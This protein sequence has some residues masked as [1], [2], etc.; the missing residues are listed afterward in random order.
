M[1]S[2][3]HIYIYIASYSKYTIHR[4]HNSFLPLP[5]VCP[6]SRRQRC[7]GAAPASSQRKRGDFF[8]IL[9]F[10]MFLSCFYIYGEW[11]ITMANGILMGF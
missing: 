11:D 9:W 8:E 4:F 1:Y 5:G 2:I 10:I 7:G 6:R 3:T